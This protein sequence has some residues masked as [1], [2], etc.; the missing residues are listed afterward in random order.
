MGFGFALLLLLSALQKKNC[1]QMKPT[2][3]MEKWKKTE[4]GGGKTGR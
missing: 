3:K 1:S 2:K 4:G